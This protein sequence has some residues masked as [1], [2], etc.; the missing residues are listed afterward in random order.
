MTFNIMA[1]SITIKNA[2]LGIITFTT[3]MLS[4][5]YTLSVIYAECH[6]SA[7]YAE[8]RYAERRGAP[9]RPLPVSTIW[10][11]YLP[12]TT[13]TTFRFSVRKWSVPTAKWHLASWRRPAVLSARQFPKLHFVNFSKTALSC[14]SLLTCWHDK[15]WGRIFSHVRPFYEWAVSDLDP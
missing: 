3:A 2:T 1:L 9:F 13:T 15:I 11:L 4:V 8:C 12:P 7:H 10:D 14:G 5:T 6:K